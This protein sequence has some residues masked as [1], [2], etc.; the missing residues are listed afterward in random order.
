MCLL[1]EDQYLLCPPGPVA[2]VSTSK[3]LVSTFYILMYTSIPTIFE[4][5]NLATFLS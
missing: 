5:K 1:S 2:S 4:Q 3:D